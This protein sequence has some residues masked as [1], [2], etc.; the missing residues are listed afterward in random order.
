M[1][2]SSIE[3]NKRDG[4]EAICNRDLNSPYRLPRSIKDDFEN[5]NSGNSNEDV[6]MLSPQQM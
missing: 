5:N 4:E 1:L 6:E 3:D 2:S